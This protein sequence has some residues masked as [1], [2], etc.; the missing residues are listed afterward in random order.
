MKPIPLIVAVLFAARV[1]SATDAE[2]VKLID[3]KPL[4]AGHQVVPIFASGHPALKALADADK[5]E[6]WTNQNG[7]V[8]KVNNIH[9]PTLE[10]YLAPPEKANGMS[11][12]LAP[13]GG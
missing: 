3:P 2:P 7:R 1:A 4:T 9:V 8:A 5:E 10:L 12:I 11:V 6:I 13:G